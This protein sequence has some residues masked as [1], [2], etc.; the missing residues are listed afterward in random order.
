MHFVARGDEPERLVVALVAGCSASQ[1]NQPR[2]A[3]AARSQESLAIRLRGGNSVVTVAPQTNVL[4]GG[5][6]KPLFMGIDVQLLSYFAF[7]SVPIPEPLHATALA[8][9]TPPPLILGVHT[10]VHT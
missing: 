3:I 7:W 9:S 4:R 1:L 6:S 8:P 5:G 10:R 2:P